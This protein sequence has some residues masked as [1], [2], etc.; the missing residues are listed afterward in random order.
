MKS[1][2]INGI[3][4]RFYDHLYAVSRKGLVLRKLESYE[5]KPRPDGYV[6]VGRRRLLHRMV[7]TC[8]CEK[9]DGA[10]HVHHKNHKR[11]DNCASNLEWVTPKTHMNEFH[12]DVSRGHSMSDAG[13][14]KLRDMRLGSVTSEE[15]KQKQRAA[16]LRIGCKPPPRKVGTKCSPEAI[17]KMKQNS[18]NAMQCEV[19]GILYRSF[20][21]AG[22]AL[23]EKPHSLRKRCLSK[24][25]P[26]YRV[27]E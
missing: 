1:I 12:A 7:A 2:T 3:T 9:P 19:N 15:T 25:F 16:S 11:N 4:Y 13:K 21:E 24:N 8:W 17:L 6:S 20:N 10:N 27:R 26:N 23:G 5:P 18:P 14:Q 22:A